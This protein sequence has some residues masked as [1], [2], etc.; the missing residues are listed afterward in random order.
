MKRISDQY[1]FFR[2]DQ[3]L[4]RARVFAD[5]A[6]QIAASGLKFRR[7][8]D[9]PAAFPSIT[10]NQN[11]ENNL[12]QFEQTRDY[13][14]GFLT[15]SEDALRNMLDEMIR[16]KELCI[17]QM[18]APWDAET[19]QMIGHEVKEANN[20]IILLG[21]T[22][23]MDKFVFAGFRHQ[24]PPISQ[25]GLYHGDDGQIFLQMNEAVF[26]PINIIGSEIF[27]WQPNDQEE[28]KLIKNLRS[29]VFALQNND[30]KALGQSMSQIDEHINHLLSLI[31]TVGS[32][33]KVT[34]SLQE[35]D[36]L[37][38]LRLAEKRV[39]L[40]GADPIEAATDLKRAEHV[41]NYVLQASSKLLDQTLVSY[42]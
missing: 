32:R 28:S 5:E 26:N 8:S 38:K 9:N 1:R 20:H 13:A 25:E 7:V 11:Q 15:A 14:K 12:K 10:K 40:E 6:Q 39:K 21:N 24:T 17:Q 18:N 35:L 27:E 31:T 42:L 36:D 22:K 4:H 41:V 30:T 3:R 23:F 19:R 2:N 33:I 34:N 29:I 37:H 16:I